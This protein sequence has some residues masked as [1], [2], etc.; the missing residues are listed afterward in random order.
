VKGEDV[1]VRVEGDA[2]GE[3][4]QGAGKVG[5][6]LGVRGVTPGT[7]DR[8]EESIAVGEAAGCG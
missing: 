5:G 8:P 7:R 6:G 3:A 2:A 1:G 4:V